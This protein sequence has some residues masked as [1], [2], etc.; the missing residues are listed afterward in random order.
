[1]ARLTLAR[2]LRLALLGLTV[3]LAAVA[4]GGVA[5]LYSTRQTYEDRL[6]EAYQLQTAASRLLAAG[7]VAEAPLPTAAGPGG[8][9][10]RA[11]AKRAFDVTLADARRLAAGD[12]ASAA[13]VQA[14]ARNQQRA[15]AKPSADAAPL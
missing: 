8:A 10:Q 6:A 12:R 3:V 13:D 4:A 11:A 7:N 15:R 9:A 1:M 2:S 5:F 14:A